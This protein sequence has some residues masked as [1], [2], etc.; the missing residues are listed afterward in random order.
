M[1]PLDPLVSAGELTQ[2]LTRAASNLDT[3]PP[4]TPL[5]RQ[6]GQPDRPEVAGHTL[7]SPT[8]DRVLNKE[9]SL[10]A[11]KKGCVP[12]SPPRGAR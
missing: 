10:W 1:G 6:A 11:E 4:S 12:Q 7:S 2:W 9:G 5:K 3:R 8:Q